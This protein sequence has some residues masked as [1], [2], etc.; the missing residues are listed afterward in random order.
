MTQIQQK[1]KQQQQQQQQQ[2]QEI[3]ISLVPYI[4]MQY[5]KTQQIPCTFMSVPLKFKK[6]V[7]GKLTDYV[8][9]KQFYSIIGGPGTT[10]PLSYTQITPKQP[11]TLHREYVEYPTTNTSII[12]A[13]YTIK[14]RN[15]P[16][17]TF[18][19]KLIQWHNDPEQQ[20]QG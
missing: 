7:L 16:I 10:I 11:Y 19:R 1:Q 5:M 2:A 6:E 9:T 4:D 12:G 18:T 14:K 3:P 13:E 20:K 17:V 8:T 15:K